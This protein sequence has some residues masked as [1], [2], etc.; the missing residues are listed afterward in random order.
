MSLQKSKNRIN[1]YQG[2][3]GQMLPGGRLVSGMQKLSGILSYSRQFM[4]IGAHGSC[5]LEINLF[6]A[7][8]VAL[9]NRL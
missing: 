4:G 7:Q 9:K 8:S 3:G 1:F 6:S 5:C 2:F